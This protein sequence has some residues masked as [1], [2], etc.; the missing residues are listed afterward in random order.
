MPPSACWKRPSRRPTAPVKAPRSWPNSSLSSRLSAS[1]AQCSLTNGPLAPRASRRWSARCRDQLLAGAALAGQEHR[2]ARAGDLLDDLEH[3][4]HGRA[5]P[6]DVLARGP[7]RQPA[8]HARGLGAELLVIEDPGQ[9]DQQL[10]EVDRLGQVVR[11]AGAHRVDRR[12]DRAERG[13]HH[14]GRRLVL[15]ADLLDQLDAVHAGHL[16]VGH[17]H[18]RGEGVELAER[19]EGVCGGLYLVPFVAQELGE[20]GPRVDLVV[21]NQDSAECGHGGAHCEARAMG[22]LPGWVVVW[23]AKLTRV[24]TA[25]GNWSPPNSNQ[26]TWR[27]PQS[28]QLLRAAH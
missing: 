13:H 6:D 23:V 11:S 19:L 25:P 1:A 15:G 14:H 9:D 5:R 21:D 16:E 8:P 26:V 4:L 3:A 7:L 28:P 27:A 17:D 12:V 24:P 10:L 18:V 22:D 20:R 2:R